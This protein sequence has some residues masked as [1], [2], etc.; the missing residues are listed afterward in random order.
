MKTTVRAWLGE[1]RCPNGHHSEVAYTLPDF[2]DA[3]ALYQCPASGDLFAISPDAEHYIGP[4]WDTLRSNTQCPTCGISLET[5][6]YY[7]DAYRCPICG[8]SSH[9]VVDLRRYPDESL[10]T[11]VACWNPYARGDLGVSS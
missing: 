8:E 11:E 10:T 4:P 3:P 5:A 6:P 1:A 9:Y 2:G 7:P